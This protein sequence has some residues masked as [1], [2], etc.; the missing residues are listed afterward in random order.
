MIDLDEYFNSVTRIDSE[1]AS[2]YERLFAN[3]ISKVARGIAVCAITMGFTLAQ[4]RDVAS[5]QTVSTNQ[6]TWS[7]LVND[8]NF[9]DV[10][11]LLKY[12]GLNQYVETDRFTAFFPTNAAFD[13]HPGVLQGLL[14]ER[15]RAFPDT[16]A[17]VTFMRSHAIYDMYPLSVFTGKNTTLTSISGN[18]IEID[19][20]HPGTYTVRWVSVNSQIAIAHVVDHPIITSN[21]I[22][23]PVDNV[24][25]INPP[26]Q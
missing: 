24:M 21:A 1:W 12:A 6:D 15:T 11:A 10:V 19:G 3:V 7:V 20:T 4:P 13:S 8:P 14:K 16:T 22:I 23:Y 25:L 5:A 2:K 17:A 9:S 18:Q 26:A